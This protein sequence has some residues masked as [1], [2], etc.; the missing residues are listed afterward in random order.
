MVY[1]KTAYIEPI[2]VTAA[3]AVSLLQGDAKQMESAAV[4]LP[5]APAANS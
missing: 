5:E 4:S 2:K 3:A 1:A